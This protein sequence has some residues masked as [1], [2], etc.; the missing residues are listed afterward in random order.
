MT[1]KRLDPVHPGDILTEILEE[2]SISAYALAKA[3]SKA[4]IQVSR[5]LRGQAAVTVDMAR[6][7]GAALGTS[8]E[9]WI[10]SQSQYDLECAEIKT[11]IL[12]IKPQVMSITM[13]KD[14]VPA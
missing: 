6:R 4:P 12:E 13:S 11:S 5:I 8:A 1:E 14:E 2:Q 9:M 10:N 3:I 7:I